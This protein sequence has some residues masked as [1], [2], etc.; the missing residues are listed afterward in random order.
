VR[1]FSP[2]QSVGALAPRLVTRY[3]AYFAAIVPPSLNA[4][5]VILSAAACAVVASANIASAVIA[6]LL[7]LRMA[8]VPHNPEERMCIDEPVMTTGLPRC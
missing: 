1:H 4:P 3:P 7:L 2:P 8:I 6:I 5:E